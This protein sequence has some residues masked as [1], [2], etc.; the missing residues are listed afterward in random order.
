MRAG[1]AWVLE[2]DLAAP[3]ATGPGNTGT[4]VRASSWDGVLA[5]ATLTLAGAGWTITGD[6]P[7]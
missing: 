3:Q 5:S 4:P 6:A 1:T 7:L 2:D